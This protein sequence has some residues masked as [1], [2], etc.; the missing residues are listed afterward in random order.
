M[1]KAFTKEDDQA[2]DDDLVTGWAITTLSGNR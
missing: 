2:V 1:S